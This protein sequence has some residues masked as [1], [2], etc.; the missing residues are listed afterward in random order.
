MTFISGEI[1][2]RNNCTFVLVSQFSHHRFYRKKNTAEL[3]SN[4][5]D[6]APLWFI[7]EQ[8]FY[9]LVVLTVRAW[10]AFFREDRREMFDDWTPR[11][12]PSEREN[13]IHSQNNSFFL[14]SAV[15]LANITELPFHIL[16]FCLLPATRF[17]RE[18][19]VKYVRQDG[20]MIQSNGNCPGQRR[21][22]RWS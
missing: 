6:A 2:T 10:W 20:Y 18:Y 11:S 12:R 21:Q 7:S 4:C 5:H 3:S 19:E 14:F 15:Y 1:G 17:F 8:F 9:L 22:R 13:E 16:Y